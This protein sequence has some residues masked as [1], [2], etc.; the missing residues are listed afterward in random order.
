MRDQFG[1]NA[2]S[3][4]LFRDCLV[5]CLQRVSNGV[6]VHTD[7]IDL[8]QFF[9]GGLIRFVP[10]RLPYCSGTV[11][12]KDIHMNEKELTAKEEAF[13]VAYTTIG[14]ET[15]SRELIFACTER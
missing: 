3:S 12:F 13:C 7:R 10:G 2:F 5:G 9:C 15:F 11:L 6:P 14:S 8:S 4:G 1:F